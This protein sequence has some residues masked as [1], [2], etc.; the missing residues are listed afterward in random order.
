MRKR[1]Y[2]LTSLI[3]TLEATSLRAAVRRDEG[4]TLAE[5][6]LILALVALFVTGAIFFLRKQISDLFSSIGSQI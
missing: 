5:Y 1:L 4:Q 2:T 3:L 6:A